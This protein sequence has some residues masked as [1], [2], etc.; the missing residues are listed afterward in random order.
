MTALTLM[1]PVQI[2]IGLGIILIV[3]GVL[4]LFTGKLLLRVVTSMGLG[5]V[6][7]YLGYLALRH[8]GFSEVFRLL[9]FL[10]L[11]V[12]LA[13]L[14]WIVFKVAYALTFGYLFYT[15]II[16]YLPENTPLILLILL[17][18]LV[19]AG[20]YLIVEYLVEIASLIAGSLTIYVGFTLVSGN[21]VFSLI[22]TGILLLFRILI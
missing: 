17:G 21:T 19:I 20:M 8:L 15:S 16:I 14:G 22:L 3:V 18:G 12:T 1:D 11:F 2:D 6:V 7:A 13:P 10:I 4:V 9:V 5:F